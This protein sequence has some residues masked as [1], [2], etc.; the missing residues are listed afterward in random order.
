MKDKTSGM[1]DIS[2]PQVT[3]NSACSDKTESL[4]MPDNSLIQ[5]ILI[6]V[7]SHAQYWCS[8]IILHTVLL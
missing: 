1:L 4:T 3:T 7:L 5:Q 2:K 6:T 8:D